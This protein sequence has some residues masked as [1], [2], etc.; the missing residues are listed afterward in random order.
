MENKHIQQIDFSNPNADK[1]TSGTTNKPVENRKTAMQELFDNLE[2]I[3]IIIPNGVKKIFLEKDKDQ[4]RKTYSQGWTTRERFDDLVP[5]IIY[6]L[7]LDYEEKQE[8]A[9]EQYYNKNYEQTR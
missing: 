4:M 5:D 9:F 7:G 3:D 6:P 2:A 1:I 8:Y